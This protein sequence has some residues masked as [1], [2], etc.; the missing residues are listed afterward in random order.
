MIGAH[1]DHL[2]YGGE[3]SMK[4]NE[5]A[6]HHG[7]D[8]NASGDGGGAA[9]GRDASRR[10]SSPA[11]TT[12]A[13]SS[14]ALFSGEEVGLAGLVAGFVGHAAVRRPST[15]AMINLDMVGML[16]DDRLIVLG[17]RFRA[18]VESGL[19]RGSR[20]RQASTSLRAATATGRPIRPASTRSRSRCSTSSPARTIAT[21]RPRIWRRRSTTQGARN[22]VD[23]HRARSARRW[24]AATR[25]AAVRARA[26]APAMEGDW[27]GYGA[28]LGT[29]PD[30][31]AMER[32]R[33][34]A[35]RRRPSGRARG[36]RR[37]SAAATASSR[38]RARAS[39][40]S[41]T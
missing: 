3:G 34:R 8:D 7:A 20:P 5:H 4:P 38:W 31:R 25:D 30:Y 17:H 22:V 35:A 33:R 12:A 40:T 28:Y 1:Y 10:I 21:T 29:V 13:R 24:R 9:R 23:L 19:V 18:A 27:R 32:D 15:V 41:T 37:A 36:H 6:I 16:R 39:R 2:G 11:S 26:A 14:F